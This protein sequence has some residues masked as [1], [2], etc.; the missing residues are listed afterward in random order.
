MRRGNVLTM[1]KGMGAMRGIEKLKTIFELFEGLKEESRRGGKGKGGSITG[2][3]DEVE[4]TAD[5]S[6]DVIRKSR[7]S[8]K[9]MLIE[10]KVARLK[11][12]IE[13][14]QRYEK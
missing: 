13:N 2:V 4:V 14:L 10:S 6:R 12:D 11:I 9:E 8:V 3:F 7:E 1:E 5:E